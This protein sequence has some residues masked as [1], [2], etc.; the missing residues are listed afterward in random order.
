MKKKYIKPKL[1]NIITV[2]GGKNQVQLDERMGQTKIIMLGDHIVE[3]FESNKIHTS[4][5]TNL[6]NP[7]GSN[8]LKN[9]DTIGTESAKINFT[10]TPASQ[11]IGPS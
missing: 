3:N 4:K 9:S 11:Q 10:N 2:R 6:H 7:V 5:T 8:W 1:V